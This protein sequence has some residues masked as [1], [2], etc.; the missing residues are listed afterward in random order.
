VTLIADSKVLEKAA[1]PWPS[2][3]AEKDSGLRS[4]EAISDILTAKVPMS[5]LLRKHL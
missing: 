3:R 4:V 2:G 1:W 5:F